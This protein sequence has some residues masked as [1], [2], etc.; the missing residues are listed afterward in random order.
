LLAGTRGTKVKINKK[1]SKKRLLHE[2]TFNIAV[3]AVFTYASFIFFKGIEIDKNAVIASA[4]CGLLA[5]YQLYAVIVFIVS[6]NFELILEDRYFSYKSY[7]TDIQED[8]KEIKRMKVIS[9]PMGHIIGDEH[10][11]RIRLNRRRYVFIYIFLGSRR[12]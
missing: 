2:I 8:Y 10:I 1:M 5:V 3:I 6:E 4:I 9:K 7:F 12:G 11:L